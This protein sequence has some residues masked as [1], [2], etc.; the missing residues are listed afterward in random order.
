MPLPE[1]PEPAPILGSLPPSSV[2]RATGF[3]PSHG[4][5]FVIHSLLSPLFLITIPILPLGPPGGSRIIPLFPDQEISTHYS[6][7]N[8]DCYFACNVIY[9]EALGINTGISLGG[10]SSFQLPHKYNPYFRGE[11]TQCWRLSDVS[12]V[13]G[14]LCGGGMGKYGHR[15]NEAGGH[16]QGLLWSGGRTHTD[17]RSLCIQKSLGSCLLTFNMKEQVQGNGL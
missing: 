5:T 3:G 2:S 10:G 16:C 1:I 15:V 7:C 13:T 17:L 11:E 12:E 9:S 8:F 14:W 6:I 4:E